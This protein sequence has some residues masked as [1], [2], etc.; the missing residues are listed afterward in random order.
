V[1]FG[2]I[3][4]N[5]LQYSKKPRFVKKFEQISTNFQKEGRI[6]FLFK[7]SKNRYFT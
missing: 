5:F 4:L 6:K 2:P 7:F 1:F 3:G